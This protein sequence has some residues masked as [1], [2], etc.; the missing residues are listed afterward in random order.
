MPFK[1]PFQFCVVNLSEFKRDFRACFLSVTHF[2]TVGNLAITL[3]KKG[4]EHAIT[5]DIERITAFLLF[6]V[7]LPQ[8][9]AVSGT[10]TF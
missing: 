7:Q 3:N 9:N 2:R 6:I 8:V 10:E 1:Q 5:P 4:L